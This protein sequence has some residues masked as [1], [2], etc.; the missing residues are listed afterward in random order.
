MTTTTGVFSLRSGY[1][2]KALIVRS[3]DLMSTHSACRGELFNRSLPKS[4]YSSP[5]K[6]CETEI[7]IKATAKRMR[8]MTDVNRSVGYAV[9]DV[10]VD[11]RQNIASRL[12]RPGP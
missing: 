2:T 6:S 8:C 11:F 7:K 3:P 12:Q 10:A 9:G 4:L 1:T 5:E